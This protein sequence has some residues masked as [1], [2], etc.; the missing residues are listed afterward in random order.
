MEDHSVLWATADTEGDTEG[1]E[2]GDQPMRA[3]RALP[4]GW[5]G[6]SHWSWA[7][8]FMNGVTLGKSLNRC[9]CF[10]FYKMRII[11]IPI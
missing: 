7:L 5:V 1:A 8:P 9:A 4:Q 6:A 11:A 3:Q 10:H 2:P